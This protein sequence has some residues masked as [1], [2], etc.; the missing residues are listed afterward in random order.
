MLRSGTGLGCS[1]RHGHAAL[2]ALCKCAPWLG[3]ACF[4]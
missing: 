1:L 3:L 4:S 2:R